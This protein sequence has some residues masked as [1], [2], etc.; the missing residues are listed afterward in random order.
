MK[1]ENSIPV[2]QTNYRKLA[3]DIIEK[4]MPGESVLFDR[5]EGD[6]IRNALNVALY[7]NQVKDKKFVTR[8]DRANGGIRIWRSE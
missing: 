6:K 3:M 8:Q 7:R 5:Y 2:P 1:I 4:L